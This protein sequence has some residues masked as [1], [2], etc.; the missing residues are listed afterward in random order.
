MS[1]ERRKRACHSKSSL[2]FFTK[3][4]QSESRATSGAWA[5]SA[6]SLCFMYARSAWYAKHL[7]NGL[8]STLLGIC[9][10]SVW[11]LKSLN[12]SFELE[13]ILGC[14]NIIVPNLQIDRQCRGTRGRARRAQHTKG[15]LGTR[16]QGM[17][18][19]RASGKTASLP[20]PMHLR[21]TCPSDNPNLAE[22]PWAVR[23]ASRMRECR[24]ALH[25]GS[26]KGIRQPSQPSRPQ[27]WPHFWIES[28]REGR[29]WK[30]KS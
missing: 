25:S 11:P 20:A 14:S 17:R 6:P 10:L 24:P 9:K 21:Q 27:Q 15:R 5:R 2:L 19:G 1:R 18:L 26:N 13:C 8:C 12:D 22:R 3:Y 30:G 16:R 7:R 29:S 23:A 28:Y 4:G